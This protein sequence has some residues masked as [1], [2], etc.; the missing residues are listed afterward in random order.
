MIICFLDNSCAGR[1]LSPC[2]L[3]CFHRQA[4]SQRLRP[5]SLLPVYYGLMLLLDVERTC[6]VFGTT[7]FLPFREPMT[8]GSLLREPMTPDSRFRE[9]M[10]P[11][12]LFR[13]DTILRMPSFA[14]SRSWALRFSGLPLG[15]KGASSSRPS[16]MFMLVSQR[17]LI[18]ADSAFW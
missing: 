16:M 7:L 1:T 4:S 10:T 6:L 9:P 2:A 13:E 12:R 17:F 14:F 11:G 18:L 8:L 3:S 15:K 5:L